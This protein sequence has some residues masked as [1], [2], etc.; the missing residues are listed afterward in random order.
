ML[1]TTSAN[2][3]VTPVHNRMP[4]LLDQ[5]G[6]DEWINE[7]EVAPLH[8]FKPAANDFLSVVKV[9]TA[10]NSTRNKGPSTH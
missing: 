2:D 1:I 4:V 9:G 8:L 6:I 7:D 10:V 3:V 5:D